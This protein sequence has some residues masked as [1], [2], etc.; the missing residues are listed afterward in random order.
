MFNFHNVF[1]KTVVGDRIK[2]LL[3]G[4]HLHHSIMI[5]VQADKI[6]PQI[7]NNHKFNYI[8]PERHTGFSIYL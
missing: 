6:S 8:T 1:S 5:H 7:F 4:K 2:K 3:K